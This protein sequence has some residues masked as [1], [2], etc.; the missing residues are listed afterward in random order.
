MGAPVYLVSNSIF[1]Q[2]V[3]ATPK[4]SVHVAFREKPNANARPI[5]S[6]RPNFAT[7][8]TE[9]VSAAPPTIIASLMAVELPA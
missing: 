5:L 1:A 8:T 6:A 4:Q 2:V 7:S 3:F 9:H